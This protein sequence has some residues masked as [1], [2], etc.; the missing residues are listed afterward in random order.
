M[1]RIGLL[2]EQFLTF[3]LQIFS[4]FIDILDDI[5]WLFCDDVLHDFIVDFF[6]DVLDLDTFQNCFNSELFKNFPTLPLVYLLI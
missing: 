4:L 6:C 5:L 2:F 1:W 3:C